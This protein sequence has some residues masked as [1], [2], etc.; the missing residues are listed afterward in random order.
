MIDNINKL[1]AKF[2]VEEDRYDQVIK[3][4]SEVPKMH[5][6]IN[7]CVRKIAVFEKEKWSAFEESYFVERCL[8]MLIH[9]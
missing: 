4:M 6:T 8:P 3:Q 1:F 9:L 5:A 2:K 7:Q